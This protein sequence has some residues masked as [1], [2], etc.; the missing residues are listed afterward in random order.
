MYYFRKSQEFVSAVQN[1][2]EVGVTPP[3]T[4]STNNTGY[5]EPA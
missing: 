3:A 2:V 4:S 5:P 1:H